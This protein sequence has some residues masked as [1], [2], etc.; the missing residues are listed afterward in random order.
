MSLPTLIVSVLS[1]PRPRPMGTTIRSA[2]VIQSNM[3]ACD[4]YENVVR[5]NLACPR[6]ARCKVSGHASFAA[7]VA[8]RS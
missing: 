7:L 8:D 4:V 1:R 5:P 6:V 3:D 2:E